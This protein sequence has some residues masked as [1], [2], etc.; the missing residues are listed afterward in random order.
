MRLRS[1]HRRA[2][3]HSLERTLAQ[4]RVLLSLL[5]VG[6]AGAALG[7]G[8]PSIPADLEHQGTE[9]N[10]GMGTWLGAYGETMSVGGFGQ[11]DYLT[12]LPAL[13]DWNLGGSASGSPLV[14][15][16][17][18]NGWLASVRGPLGSTAVYLFP[19]VGTQTPG[20][21]LQ[22]PSSGDVEAVAVGSNVLA[23]GRPSAFANSGRV[24]VWKNNH[25]SWDPD[26]TF[27]LT[28][29]E[30]F[31]AAVDVD[32]DD[33]SSTLAIGIPGG[34]GDSGRVQIWRR[35]GGSWALE[36]TLTAP[37]DQV[38]NDFGAA[39]DVDG[40]W[41]AVGAP[42]HDSEFPEPQGTNSGAV[43]L[44]R[45]DSSG[46]WMLAAYMVGTDGDHFGAS[47][48]M[49]S[50][51]L[52]VGAPLEDINSHPDITNAGRVHL[53][54]RSNGLWGYAAALHA[55][56]P[57]AFN[58]LGASVGISARGVVSGAPQWNAPEQNNAGIVYTWT[59][60][61]PLFVDGFETGDTQAWSSAVP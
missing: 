57:G 3:R 38:D 39:L 29:S 36:G 13:E 50:A 28:N 5:M 34:P 25:G 33:T 31:G 27:L 23:L 60:T 59:G 1:R 52:A 49:R 19:W 7:G 2:T 40:P 43:Y 24:T 58:H 6:V 4:T 46:T 22:I 15:L 21:L 47:V 61:V 20:P 12:W 18:E 17:V 48:A 45:R 10:G 51:T 16:D 30:A 44:Y 54:R 26:I 8:I 9:A 32:S 55:P 56:N 53:Y 35:A 37:G 14:G 42:L 41:L 11:E